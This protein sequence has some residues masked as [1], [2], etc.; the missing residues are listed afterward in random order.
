M[1]TLKWLIV[2]EIPRLL[3]KR[4]GIGSMASDANGTRNKLQNTTGMDPIDAL[5]FRLGE[6]G[7]N[8][9]VGNSWI[10]KEKYD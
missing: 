10:W 1:H 9:I 6:K 8:K 7:G 5:T 4:R 3:T 2:R